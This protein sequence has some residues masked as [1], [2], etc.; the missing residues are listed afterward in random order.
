MA[1]ADPLTG[2]AVRTVDQAIRRMRA[3][4]GVLPPGDGLA[5]FNRM[6][7]AVTELVGA[8]ITKRFFADPVFM[9]RL[10]V[11]FANLYFGAVRS[12]LTRPQRAPRCWK[13]LLDRRDVEG[14]IPLQFAFAGMNA[15]INHD[16]AVA[17]VSTCAL[18]R[19]SP[20]G[21]PHRR[22]FRRVNA[23]LA[24]AEEQIRESFEEGLILEIDRRVQVDNILGNWSIEAARE[25]AWTNA[26]ALWAIRDIG[27]LRN[28]F[29]KVLDRTVGFAGR[30]LLTPVLI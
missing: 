2:P 22:D 5:C 16:L 27:F 30:G 12:Y 23:L 15:H 14:I 24:A 29:L 4:A 20:G 11:A 13:A 21:G 17:V 8:Q 25:A 26:S 10:D 18:L 28:E 19:T 6:Y 7:L 1:A 3:I 9:D